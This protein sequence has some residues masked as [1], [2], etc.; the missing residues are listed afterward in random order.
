MLSILFCMDLSNEDSPD[1]QKQRRSDVNVSAQYFK[2]ANII[3]LIARLL[4]RQGHRTRTP[5]LQRNSCYIC[6]YDINSRMI[7]NN[8]IKFQ[9]SAISVGDFVTPRECQREKR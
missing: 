2:H 7:Q 3:P 8:T 9:G 6:H 4:Q 1:I 5:V